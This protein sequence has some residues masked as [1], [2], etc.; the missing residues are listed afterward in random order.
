MGAT[1]KQR[2]FGARGIVHLR[3]QTLLV[4]T[5]QEIADV[6]ERMQ[7]RLLLHT[8]QQQ[9]QQ[10]GNDLAEHFRIGACLTR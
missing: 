3:L 1:G 7:L 2:A 8:D 10:D 9:G 5:M 6:R 4:R